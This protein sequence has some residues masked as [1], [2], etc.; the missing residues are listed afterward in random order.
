M[1]DAR[2]REM[3]SRLTPC[4]PIRILNPLA[5]AAAEIV[6]KWHNKAVAGLRPETRYN[7]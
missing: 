5:W 7:Y 4:T 3:I 1:W 6:R 2:D